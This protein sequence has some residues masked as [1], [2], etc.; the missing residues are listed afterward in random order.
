MDA[1][2]SEGVIVADNSMFDIADPSGYPGER[3]QIPVESSGSLMAYPCWLAKDHKGPC[4]SPE[5]A[6]SQ[7]IRQRWLDGQKEQQQALAQDVQAQAAVHSFAPAPEPP[8]E[9]VQAP[10]AP[11]AQPEVAQPP[12]E[13]PDAIEPTKQR[14]GDQ[15][16]P[17][18]DQDRSMSIQ[19]V[20]IQ[21]IEKRK[22]V[23][24]ERYGTLLYAFNGRDSARDA[25]EEA[26]DLVMYLT[27]MRVEY[28]AVR[29]E[30][31]ALHDALSHTI[32]TKKVGLPTLEIM[33]AA[34]Q[35]VRDVVEPG[36]RG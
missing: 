20:V 9:P 16:L 18:Q 22:G 17:H 1:D 8:P 24:L 10:V 15:P 5:N 26:L 14:E 12:A 7:T 19:D 36:W 32:E 23:G 21:E 29:S 25:Q 6:R 35:R 28:E 3:C 4:A 34:V 13:V 2:V 33:L 31:A 27:T 11:P 30:V